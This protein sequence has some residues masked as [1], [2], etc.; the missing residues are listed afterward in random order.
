MNNKY[1]IVTTDNGRNIS[2]RDGIPC[3]ICNRQMHVTSG[4]I[5]HDGDGRLNLECYY[6]GAELST[7]FSSITTL[8]E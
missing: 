2:T 7:R 3:P 6:C 1:H 5:N 4:E 8:I